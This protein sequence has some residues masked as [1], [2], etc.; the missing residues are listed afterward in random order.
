MWGDLFFSLKIFGG[1]REMNSS[2]ERLI[3]ALDLVHKAMNSPNAYENGKETT[4]STLRRGCLDLRRDVVQLEGDEFT[5]ELIQDAWLFLIEL[6]KARLRRKHAVECINIMLGSPKW[7][8]ILRSSDKIRAK[9]PEVSKDMQVALGLSQMESP[10]LTP[11]TAKLSVA[12]AVPPLQRKASVVPPPISLTKSA[13]PKSKIKRGTSRLD[14]DPTCTPQP[15][16]PTP[17]VLYADTTPATSP[18]VPDLVSEES[19]VLPGRKPPDPPSPEINPHNPFRMDFNPFKDARGKQMMR[20]RAWG[21]KGRVEW[22]EES[23]RVPP[24][25]EAWW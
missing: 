1:H 19:S 9:L 10:V 15:E 18:P 11:S 24:L 16:P 2:K 5:P 12:S 22:W 17:V 23:N 20:D 25:P 14:D 21:T 3:E 4:F 6:S 7:T 13:R 8:S